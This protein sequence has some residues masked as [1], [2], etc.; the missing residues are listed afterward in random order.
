MGATVRPAWIPGVLAAF[1][2]AM[3]MVSPAVAGVRDERPNL[4]GGELGGRG[5]A[6]TL[7][8]E[9]FFSNAFGAGFGFMAIGT[10]DGMATIAPVYLSFVPGDTHSLYL[11][12]GLA[13]IGGGGSV[14]DYESD[15]L[16]QAAIGYHYHSTSGFFVRPLFTYMVPTTDSDGEFLIWPGITIGGS[17]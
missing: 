10:D 15:L 2:L 5:I 12:G 6:L 8:Y 1:A 17:F 11:A 4:V 7:N 3:S 9:R 13:F 14:E 16:F